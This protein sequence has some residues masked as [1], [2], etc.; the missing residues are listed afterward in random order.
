MLP[1][2]SV[3]V[4]Y[5]TLLRPTALH[6]QT[7]DPRLDSFALGRYARLVSNYSRAFGV[8][9]PDYLSWV[10]RHEDQDGDRADGERLAPKERC[11]IYSKRVAANVGGGR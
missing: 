6:A 7:T 4:T 1:V 10:P 11:R 3:S 9:T 8:A 2:V 5:S